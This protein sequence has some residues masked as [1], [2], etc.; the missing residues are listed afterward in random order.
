[1]L[2]KLLGEGIEYLFVSN[3]DNLG[4]RGRE[5]GKG[6]EGYRKEVGSDRIW[7]QSLPTPTQ[8]PPFAFSFTTHHPLSLGATLDLTVLE[9]S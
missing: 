9:Y 2:E 5:E 7:A 4:E 1:M 3:S 8:L 6:G